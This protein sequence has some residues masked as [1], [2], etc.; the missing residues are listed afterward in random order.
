MQ[1]DA[2]H[3]TPPGRGLGAVQ[4]GRPLQDDALCKPS[5]GRGLGAVPGGRPMQGDALRKTP[6]G[7][8]AWSSRLLLG[9]SLLWSFV[10]CNL[11]FS[12]DL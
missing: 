11:S 2:L 10:I 9:Q 3:K 8:G 4:G 1:D 12:F 5:P 6:P 7:T